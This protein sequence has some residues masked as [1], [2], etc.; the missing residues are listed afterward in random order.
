MKA[1]IAAG[2]IV[3]LVTMI[4]LLL[5]VALGPSSVD[6]LDAKATG[7]YVGGSMSTER[8]R[9]DSIDAPLIPTAESQRDSR[10]R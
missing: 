5:Y 1:I 7:H 10:Y 3:I 8:W 2:K 6:A 4:S 9:G